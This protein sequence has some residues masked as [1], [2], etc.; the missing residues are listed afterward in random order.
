[1]LYTVILRSEPVW[2]LFGFCFE[3]IPHGCFRLIRKSASAI[4]QSLTTI[5]SLLSLYIIFARQTM[6]KTI[7]S[8]LFG[9]KKSEYGFQEFASL[10]MKLHPISVFCRILMDDPNTHRSIKYPKTI[11]CKWW[12]LLWVTWA[13]LTNIYHKVCQQQKVRAWSVNV[14]NA[15]K[16]TPSTHCIF[17]WMNVPEK[18]AGWRTPSQ[19]GDWPWG[20]LAVHWTWSK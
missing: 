5:S 12:E 2:D 11:Y 3:F 17:C 19:S 18:W 13:T 16:G 6:V 20:T 10:N 1:M 14:W 15:S 4:W 7:R 8:F 9:E